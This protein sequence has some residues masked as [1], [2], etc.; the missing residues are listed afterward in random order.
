VI[1]TKTLSPEQ[2]AQIPR[3]IQRWRTVALS[4]RPIGRESARAAVYALYQAYGLPKPRFV[5]FLSSPLACHFA[6]ALVQSLRSD[7]NLGRGRTMDRIRW[8]CYLQAKHAFEE[9]F[10]DVSHLFALRIEFRS[11]IYSSPIENEIGQIEQQLLGGSRLEGGIYARLKNDVCD[12]IKDKLS[13]LPAPFHRPATDH[14]PDLLQKGIEDRPW[15]FSAR[16]DLVPLFFKGGQEAP[17]LAS[18]DFGASLGGRFPPRV[19][20]Y[21]EAFKACAL[22]C[23]WIYP[24]DTVGFVSD[25]PTE[26]HHD[27]QRRLHRADG[28]AIRFR[29]GWG[30]H[31]WH[32]LWVPARV[33]EAQHLD[34]LA[35]EAETN[36]EWRRVMLERE[37]GGRTGFDIYLQAR[38][39]HVLAEDEVHGQ[40]RRLLETRAKGG[41]PIRIVEVIN[42][43]DEPDGTRRKFY[44]G[45]MRGRT[46]HEV[47]AASYGINPD[48]YREAVRT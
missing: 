45:A 32:G 43:S 11:E 29:D 27:A 33:M 20:R 47:V 21:M 25:R 15:A 9:N 28:M 37:Y 12:L 22:A 41:G 19:E 6:R 1:V 38:Q 26:I 46:P 36:V 4:T 10:G 17:W 39:P 7:G 30:A 2:E 3:F 35:V 16:S 42:G 23:G 48:V 44:L 5:L 24:H 13:R 40:P 34:V 31:V 14:L 18:Y 8:R